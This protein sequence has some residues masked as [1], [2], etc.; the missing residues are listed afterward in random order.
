MFILSVSKAF[1]PSHPVWDRI[2]RTAS[3]GALEL[4]ALFA[5]SLRAREGEKKKKE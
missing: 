1:S 4:I 5:I 3:T 2:A